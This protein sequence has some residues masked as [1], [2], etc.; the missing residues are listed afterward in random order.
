MSLLV[1]SDGE[2]KESGECSLFGIVGAPS[3]HGDEGVDSG[4]ELTAV[5][6]RGLGEA[7][8]LLGSLH[9]TSRILRLQEH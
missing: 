6:L 1:V 4:G 9:G 8:D 2:V 7:P 5:A 3:Q